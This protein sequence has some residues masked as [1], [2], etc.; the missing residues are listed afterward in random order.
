MYQFWQIHVTTQIFPFINLTNPFNYWETTCNN[1]DRA[2][3]NKIQQEQK[4]TDVQ[5]DKTRQW[6]DLNPIKKSLKSGRGQSFAAVDQKHKLTSPDLW[7]QHTPNIMTTTTPNNFY[8][9]LK[10]EFFGG[11]STHGIL[12][13]SGF[14]KKYL[15][16]V[17]GSKW[18][19]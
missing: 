2:N 3:L 12:T 1:F 19:L 4:M 15:I 10:R 16:W 17:I 6:S 14:R 13:H 5:S 18:A 9:Q 8:G 11:D 7:R